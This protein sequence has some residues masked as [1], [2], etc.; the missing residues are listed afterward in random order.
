M[1]QQ[2]RNPASQLGGQA[3]FFFLGNV[4]TL[5]VG[6]PLQIYVA[7]MLGTGGLGVFSLI[8]GGVSLT[9]GLVSFGLAPTLVK[10][11]PFHLER[12]EF[13]CIRRLIVEG[14]SLL[15]ISGGL[16]YGVA[17]IAMRSRRMPA[18]SFRVAANRS[19]CGS[20][21]PSVSTAM[22]TAGPS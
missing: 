8:E 10:F 21:M 20:G 16:A 6:L 7:R 4:F 19:V 11:I 17:V 5:L 14:A 9:A 18:R 1:T 15:L 12:R 3:A 2:G 22:T 13:A